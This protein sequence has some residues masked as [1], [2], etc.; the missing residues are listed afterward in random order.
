MTAA[1]SSC[2]ACSSRNAPVP[3]AAQLQRQ[4]LDQ[5]VLER[6]QLQK[7][8]EDN[9]TIDA[10]TVQRTLERPRAAKPDDA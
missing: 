7:A 3:P 10:P 6:I 4:V 8:K 1:T 5:M 2:V 9:I